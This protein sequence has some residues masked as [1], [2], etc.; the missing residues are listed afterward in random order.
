MAL[1]ISPLSFVP[2][3][4]YICCNSSEFHHLSG[5]GAGFVTGGQRFLSSPS[6]FLSPAAA[7]EFDGGKRSRRKKRGSSVGGVY[8]HVIFAS[9]DYYS[10]LGVSKSANSKE[11]KAAYRR[12]A[13][14][15]CNLH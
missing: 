2:S 4:R 3:N 14:Q 1:S 7:S 10:T 12:L 9:A 15:V 8:S 13:R 11:I 6:L 5:A